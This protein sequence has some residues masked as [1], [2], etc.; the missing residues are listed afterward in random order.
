MRIRLLFLMTAVLVALAGAGVAQQP[1]FKTLANVTQLMKAIVIPS[2]D[3]L[4][5]VAVET[6]KDDK[7]WTALE[8]S[9]LALA[10]SGNLLMIGSRAKD[11][12]TW[13]QYSKAMIDAA[14]MAFKAA[15]SKNVDAVLEAGDKIYAT[16]ETCHERYMAKQR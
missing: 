15:Q 5:N 6:P 12:K 16:C 1:T 4:F 14:E 13:M 9:A 2:S 3:A 7:E 8:N 11:S 10:E